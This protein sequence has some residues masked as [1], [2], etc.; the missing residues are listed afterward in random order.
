MMAGQAPI[1]RFCPGKP[2]R[3]RLVMGTVSSL[4][5]HPLSNSSYHYLRLALSFA[6]RT[7]AQSDQIGVHIVRLKGA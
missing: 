7:P 5:I 6:P 1:W 4:A 3:P 2:L